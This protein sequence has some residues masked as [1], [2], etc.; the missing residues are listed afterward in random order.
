MVENC[1]TTAN[2]ARAH[3]SRARCAGRRVLPSPSQST[4]LPVLEGKKGI[5]SPG[6]ELRVIWPWDLVDCTLSIPPRWASRGQIPFPVFRECKGRI[7]TCRRALYKLEGRWKRTSEL[8]R[9]PKVPIPR[10]QRQRYVFRCAPDSTRLRIYDDR[11]RFEWADDKARREIR[12]RAT[13]AEA[14]A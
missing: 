9:P 11:Q 1:Y 13:D 8:G 3:T 4:A 2:L 5:V 10:R 7:A 6:T 14:G 12:Q